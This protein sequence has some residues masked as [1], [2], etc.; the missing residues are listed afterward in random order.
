MG[1]LDRRALFTS[2]AAAAL[3]AASGL[4]L[5]A[6][7]R[8][9]GTLRIALP[10]DGSLMQLAR[11]AALDNVSEIAPDG[12]LRGELA[13]HWQ[14]S[15]DA[16]RWQFHLEANAVF[17]DGTGVTAQAVAEALAALDLPGAT[18]IAPSADRVL[19]IE[20]SKPNPDLPLLLS[21][22]EFAIDKMSGPVAML[23]NGSG[24]Y[25]IDR[26]DPNRHLLATRVDPHYRGDRAGWADR[27][28]AVVIPDAG[29]RAEALRDGYVDI[30]YLPERDGLIGRGEFSY[31][32]SA[33]EFSIATTTKVGIP[34]HVD[35]N[36]PLDNGRLG[37]RW[38]TI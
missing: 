31:H 30:A 6:A 10:R 26:L 27:I 5:G 24:L 4:A 32:P 11:G 1:R 13:S 17:H 28:E 35:M 15:V 16:V 19:D 22:P 12:S 29:V 7:P 21:R 37:E 2:G 25:R 3:L 23:E 8:R 38:W 14:S 34:A 18:L 20:L 9:G 36:G 33:E